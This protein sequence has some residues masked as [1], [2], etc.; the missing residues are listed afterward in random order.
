MSEIEPLYPAER[1]PIRRRVAMFPVA[2]N[3]PDSPWLRTAEI[4]VRDRR[5]NDECCML[6]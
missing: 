5:S 4:G 1:V 3:G 6:V 2:H